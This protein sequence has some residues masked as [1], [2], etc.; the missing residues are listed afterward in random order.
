MENVSPALFLVSAALIAS[1]AIGIGN[2]IYRSASSA[3]S[4]S[5]SNMYETSSTAEVEAFNTMFKS[6]E[7]KQTGSQVS[8]FADR[9][10][11]NSDTYKDMPS[12]VPDF[13]YVP[14]NIRAS[15]IFKGEEELS[16]YHEKLEQ[17]KNRVQKKSKY[18]VSFSYDSEGL[19]NEIIVS[20]ED[21]T[22]SSSDKSSNTLSETTNTL[23][24]NDSASAIEI[25]AFNSNYESYKGEQTGSQISSLIGRL[26]SN[27]TFNSETP[28]NVPTLKLN[29]INYETFVTEDTVAE[30]NE[31]GQE[32]LNAYKEEL[33]NI[34]NGL[35]STH[36]YN[37][38]FSYDA[39][40]MISEIIVKY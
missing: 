38:N 34:R 10:I 4:D 21:A 16:E 33:G 5:I 24:T 32:T 17:V 9:L 26:L 14:D 36:V 3:I 1:V 37:V 13:N 11:A 23:S 20:K 2:A 31:E 28:N 40:G 35:E 19:L 7:G 8:A 6:Y 15:Y 27:A 30:Y 25:S 29:K 18:I 39:T 22:T 12:R